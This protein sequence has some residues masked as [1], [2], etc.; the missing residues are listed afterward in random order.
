MNRVNCRALYQHAAIGQPN[1]RLHA[2]VREVSFKPAL[3]VSFF[4]YSAGRFSTLLLKTIRNLADTY[5]G[6]M[7]V[8][9]REN[10]WGNGRRVIVK[11]VFSLK[12]SLESLEFFVAPK[13]QKL[14]EMK[15]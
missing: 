15:F 3:D 11:G 6:N 13:P 2:S 5:D 7:F 9:S 14:A 12:V 1:S 10:C 4:G 8:L